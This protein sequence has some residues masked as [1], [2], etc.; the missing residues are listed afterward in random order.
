MEGCIVEKILG[1][2]QNGRSKRIYATDD[3][4]E[5]V[6]YFKDDAQAFGGLKRGR[7]MGKGE[8]NNSVMAHIYPMLERHGIRTHFIRV[9]DERQSL[10]HRTKIIPV[11]VT[12]RNIAAG[13]LPGRIGVPVGTELA[14]PV[15]EF[16]LKN[17]YLENPMI[18]I[19]HVRALGL[20]T[21]D[22]MEF[23]SRTALKINEILT[24]YLREINIQLIDFKLEFGRLG[25]EIVLADEI[26]PDSA[27]FWDVQT[28]E[29]LGIDQFR[30]DLDDPEG[31]YQEVLNRMMGLNDQET[32]A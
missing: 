1:V 17:P 31:A 11:T 9:L 29:P 15:V 25:D 30:R 12:V 21:Q 26:T 32:K 10:V 27:R 2:L 20:A 23:I 19:T 18:N 16:N 3:P 14:V 8:V 7:I 13:S 22:E 28:H 24:A 6:M 4:D 5:A